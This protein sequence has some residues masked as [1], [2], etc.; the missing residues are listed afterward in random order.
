MKLTLPQ[1]ITLFF[2]FGWIGGQ[3]VHASYDTCLGL[4]I[5]GAAI[6]AYLNNAHKLFWT[7]VVKTYK[8][9]C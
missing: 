3:V 6:F 8:R 1:F 2:V 9:F 7:S 4:G 5:M